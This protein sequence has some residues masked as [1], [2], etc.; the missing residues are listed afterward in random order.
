MASRRILILTT[1]VILVWSTFSGCGKRAASTSSEQQYSLDEA[2]TE[3][4]TAKGEQSR[5]AEI[6]RL[7]GVWNG[8]LIS[9]TAI[10]DEVRESVTPVEGCRLMIGAHV[11]TNT[12]QPVRIVIQVP[13]DFESRVQ[14]LPPGSPVSFV[15]R[16]AY[17]PVGYRLVEI[18]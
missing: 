10:V 9:G 7:E 13:T 6:T 5:N 14:N 11:D 1:A 3:Y 12:G 18:R 17:F 16:V 4:T 15:G 2:I 8:R